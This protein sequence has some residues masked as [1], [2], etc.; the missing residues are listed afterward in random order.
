M[1]KFIASKCE[2]ASACSLAD[3]PVS[4]SYSGLGHGERPVM[5]IRVALDKPHSPIIE[6]LLGVVFGRPEGK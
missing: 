2:A 1:S 4:V 3:S 5:T 6:Q